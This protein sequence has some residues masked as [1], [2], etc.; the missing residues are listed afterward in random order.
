LRNSTFT[1]LEKL[2]LIESVTSQMRLRSCIFKGVKR[3]H[4]LFIMMSYSQAILHH[5]KCHVTCQWYIKTRHAI[6]FFKEFTARRRWSGILLF[7][8]NTVI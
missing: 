5:K 3:P 1:I 6:H 2:A 8:T 4:L 7:S